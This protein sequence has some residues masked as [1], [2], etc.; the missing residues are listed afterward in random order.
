M[1]TGLKK[2]VPRFSQLVE[3]V[4]VFTCTSNSPDMLC[5]HSFNYYD[6]KNL[7]IR[8]F[9]LRCTVSLVFMEMVPV[10]SVCDQF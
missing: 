9:L 4:C 3:V 7:V 1:C 8:H 10:M 5:D 6:H 2:G